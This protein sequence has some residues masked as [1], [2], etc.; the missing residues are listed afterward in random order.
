MCPVE[1]DLHFCNRNRITTLG[2]LDEYMCVCVCGGIYVTLFFSH[3]LNGYAIVFDFSLIVL[4]KH[5]EWKCRFFGIFGHINDLTQKKKM[6]NRS[7]HN[8]KV[9]KMS[10]HQK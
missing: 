5:L 2:W 6:E 4:S 3:S 9:E 8:T 7:H 10:I 1:H